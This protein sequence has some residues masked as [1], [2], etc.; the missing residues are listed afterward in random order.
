VRHLRDRL[1]RSIGSGGALL[2]VVIVLLTGVR[3][4]G[5]VAI[6]D[7][8]AGAITAM[9]TGSPQWQS[10]SMLA[11]SGALLCAGA[12]WALSFTTA[13]GASRARA[14]LRDQV[15]DRIAGSPET[16][17]QSVRDATRGLDDLDS[18]YTAV[19]PAAVAAI[20]IPVVLGARILSVDPLSAVII[21]LTVPLI[22]VFMV[23]IGQHTRERVTAANTALGRLSSHIT[24]LARGLPVLVGLDRDRD[25]AQAL[26]RIQD[27][28]RQRTIRT[29]RTAF[30]SAFALELI[31]TLSVA[32][33][34]VALGLRLLSGDL[35]LGMALLVLL[36]APDVFTVLRDVGAA[37][38]AS[39]DGRAALDR[40]RA[41]LAV[42]AASNARPGGDRLV[43]DGLSVRYP[44]RLRPALEPV[45]AEFEHAAITAI[46]GASGS[47]KSTL[48]AAVAGTLPQHA[49]VSGRVLGV[50]ADRIG[51]APQDPVV[52]SATV[53]EEFELFAPDRASAAAMIDRMGLRAVSELAPAAL[54]PGELR[55]VAV[56]CALLRVLGGADVLILDEPTAHLDEDA[57]AAVRAAIVELRGDTRVL[58]V[59][60]DPATLSL[61]DAVVALDASPVAV[62]PSAERAPTLSRQ[63]MPEASHA[64]PQTNGDRR[65]RLLVELLA[66]D[67]ARWA[68]AILLG[69]LATALALSLTAVSAWLI[70]TAAEQPSLMYLS[71]AIV[72]VRFFG[73]G[74]AVTRYLERL[75]SHDAVFATTDRLRLRLW[76]GIA[77]RGATSRDLLEGGSAVDYLVWLTAE[78]RD[79]LPRVI[80]PV[81]VGP[82]T[83][84]GI[85]VCAVLIAPQFGWMLGAALAATLAVAIVVTLAADRRAQ[86]SSVGIRSDLRRRVSALAGA[87]PELRANGVA[88]RA[89]AQVHRLGEAQSVAERRSS[90]P[91]GAAAAIAIGGTGLIA[92]AVVPLT[93]A[94]SLPTETIAVLTL[95]ALA[96]AEPIGSAAAGVQRIPAALALLGR[97]GR[98]TAATPAL[99]GNLPVRGPVNSVTLEAVTARWPGAASSVF[100]PVDASA[101]GPGWLVIDGPSGSGKSTLLS[102]LMG[103][104]R[105]DHGRV[106]AGDAD[107]AEL[108]VDDWRSRVAWCPQ[109]A[110]VFDSSLRGNLLL[111]QRRG[112]PPIGDTELADTLARVGLSDLLHD[113]AEGLAMRV[114]PGGRSLSGGERQ[115]LAV[116]R[117]I[118]SDADLLLLDEP[119]AHLDHPTAAAMM[120]D[121]RRATDD[122][123]VVMV[124]HRRED[125]R[126]GDRAVTLRPGSES[127]PP[128]SATPVAALQDHAG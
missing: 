128:P 63:A 36:L 53:V 76:R 9:S 13:R 47:G 58:L 55:R 51:Y 90:W 54:S 12:A 62:S 46:T 56:G 49:L 75:V 44:D 93:S 94:G 73:L 117:A 91:A 110:H 122:R 24:E 72:G 64:F 45:S 33:V 118:L 35:G 50:A 123:V 30:L 31:A 119:T 81:A 114:G 109:E 74:R 108:R 70:V 82:V 107:L 68:L 7:G 127:S 18:Y 32:L 14:R 99:G 38:H 41:L 16:D 40:V 126:P 19:I 57:A 78:L 15:I 5:L 85:T 61:A 97:V 125:R 112:R 104:L 92:A 39:Q 79:R 23:L 105:P 29:L 60:H 98:L 42:P 43:L 6:A 65:W 21:A 52:F 95:L 103:S 22:P 120:Q 26:A 67:A 87:A 48:L 89:A 86:A 3:A 106:L 100:A 102:V 10:A 113:G 59:S 34:A 124:S 77:D 80:I 111:A 84:V 4:V 121:L 37:F 83:V 20:V 11:A 71:V 116:A 115:R 101:H 1:D 96:A 88:V 28:Y 27:S 25:E 2:L 66:P 69:C 17:A 8:V